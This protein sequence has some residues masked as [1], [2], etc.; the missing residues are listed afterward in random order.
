MNQENANRLNREQ[1]LRNG[2]DTIFPL[3]YEHKSKGLTKREYIATKLLSGL[4]T[5]SSNHNDMMIEEVIR[6]T[7][8]LL[9]ELNKK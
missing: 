6:V 1:S 4:I 8:E 5:D 9:H 7:D 2:E 3:P